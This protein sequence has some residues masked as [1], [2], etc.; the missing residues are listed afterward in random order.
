M[1]KLNIVG[2]MVAVTA[3]IATAGCDDFLE[4]RNPT[5]IDSSTIDPSADAPTFSVSAMQNLWD[6]FD[7]HIVYTA[8]FSGEAWVG[9]T[10]PTR[11]DI[12]RRVVE[13]SNGTLRDE[14]YAP[15]GLAIASNEVVLGLLADAPDVG[16]NLNVARAAV[17]GGYAILLQAEGFC[18]V[19]ISRGL[20]TENLGSPLASAA[21]MGEAIERFQQAVTVG[22]A[23]GGAEATSYVNLARVGLARAHLF[24]GEYDQAIAAAAQVPAD[25]AFFAQKVDDASYRGRLGNTVYNFTLA[26][27]SLVV[28]PYYRALNDARVTAALGPSPAWTLKAQGNDLDFWRQTKYAGWDADIRLASGLEARYLAAEAQ[29]KKGDSAPAVALIAE[30][31]AAGG[32]AAATGDDVDFVAANTLLV[33]LLDQKARDFYLEGTHMGDWRRNATE[34]PYVPTAGTPYYA[35]DVGGNIGALTC[36]PTPQREVDSNPNYGG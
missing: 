12:G 11:N 32:A 17:A 24:R 4:A 27:S 29:L 23:A 25:F 21:A 2:A 9:D 36:M 13:F 34:T 31:R 16:S 35:A 7:D 19:V 6:A 3:A 26:R 22:T 33:D 18:E 5:V 15:L 14:I 10:F 30:R 28:P 8:W 1:K 20:G